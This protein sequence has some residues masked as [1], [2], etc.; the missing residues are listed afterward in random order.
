[1]SADQ[2]PAAAPVLNAPRGMPL[3]TGVS[4]MADKASLNEWSLDMAAAVR[5]GENQAA[6]AF[7][8]IAESCS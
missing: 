7:L 1:M 2:P 3:L 8:P 4:A 5:A 6:K